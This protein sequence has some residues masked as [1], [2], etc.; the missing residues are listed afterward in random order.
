MAIHVTGPDGPSAADL[1]L[2]AECP[3]G[4]L[5]PSIVDVVLG[6]SA[7]ATD[8]QRWQL[9]R[10]GGQ[11][12][13]T[14]M[15]LREN[16][17]HDGELILLATAAPPGR[18]RPPGDP[19][20]VIAATADQA[21]AAGLHRAVPTAAGL[22]ITMISAVA[23]AWSGGMGR[24]GGISAHLWT[25]AALSAATA[26]GAVVIGRT[27]RELT[28]VFS[29]GAVVFATVAGF[30][31][32]PNA[33]W[34]PAL[35]LAASCGFT[36]SILLLRLACGGTSVLTALAAITG[37]VAGV[38]AFG[39]AGSP[40][41]EAAGA[42]LTVLSLAALSAA[43]KLTVAAAG[44]GPSRAAIGDRRATVAHRI[45]TG[46]VAGWS[47][48]AM[49]GVVAVAAVAV[50]TADSPA[51]AALFAADVGFL[52]L[53]RQRTHVDAWRRIMLGA[54]GIGAMI[55][56]FTVAVSAA[57][58]HAYG[59]CALTV[60]AGVGALRRAVSEMPSN[61][62]VRHAVQLLEY[63]ALAAVVPLGAWVTGVYGVVR[64]LSLL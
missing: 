4:V 8:P 44:L 5:I 57:P 7:T 24:T 6:D 37:T 50:P 13:D 34:P 42:V 47:C 9:T 40:R 53:L 43:P 11:R 48:S 3:V 14:S 2:P 29:I 16:G 18:F 38:G 23:L 59:L 63:V 62:V 61:P 31:A 41:L 56:A 30:L 54:T 46:L 17:I 45:L 64:D 25:A 22:T 32:V 60:I 26:T 35:L 21:P 28:V 49:I 10:V 51:V 20:G 39:V 58:Q 27:A 33:S 36:V 1:M 52:L 15:T 19:S 55:A 12:V